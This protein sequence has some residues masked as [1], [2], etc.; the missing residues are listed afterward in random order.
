MG[1]R[2]KKP[3]SPTTLAA[4]GI[5]P[6]PKPTA[7]ARLTATGRRADRWRDAWALALCSIL[8][9]VVSVWGMPG[10]LTVAR[11]D[12]TWGRFT[13]GREDCTPRAGCS[14]YG[15]FSSDDGAIHIDDA[16]GYSGEGIERP[17]DSVR[18]QVVAGDKSVYGDH[19]N[20]CSTSAPPI[21][22]GSPTS[23]TGSR[24]AGGGGRAPNSGRPT[25]T[26]EHQIRK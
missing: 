5:G 7:W 4:G 20:L 16:G 19:D 2:S 23:S 15:E 9:L 13:A 18:A 1:E 12:G 3:G 11:N 8:L 6:Q 21:S 24:S 10:W 25:E 26:L 17:G 14:W 22:P